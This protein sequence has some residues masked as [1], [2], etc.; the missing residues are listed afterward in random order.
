MTIDADLPEGKYYVKELYAAFPYS[1]NAEEKTFELKYKGNEPNYKIPTKLTIK[2]DVESSTV[3]FV[4]SD[5]ASD[6][7]LVMN[8]K[9]VQTS[10]N[11]DV[12]Q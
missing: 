5:Q 2:D 12:R 4:K 6:E 11:L 3:L 8:G 10:S 1:I 9:T 7:N